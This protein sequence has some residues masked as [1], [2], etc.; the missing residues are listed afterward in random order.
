MRLIASQ[1]PFKGPYLRNASKAYC[2]QVGVK[3]HEALGLRG[4]MQI[5]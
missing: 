4:E 3:R 2:E 1:P 5:W